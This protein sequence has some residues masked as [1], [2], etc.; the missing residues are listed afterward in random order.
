MAKYNVVERPSS[1][2]NDNQ[3]PF[4]ESLKSLTRLPVVAGVNIRNKEALPELDFI[5]PTGRTKEPYP[6]LSMSNI[7]AALPDEPETRAVCVLTSYKTWV[8]RSVTYVQATGFKPKQRKKG[9][10]DDNL[11]E[12]ED[13]TPEEVLRTSKSY[14]PG[15]FG[16]V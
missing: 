7:L 11:N 9:K 6:S 3:Y 10:E 1:L 4:S 12:E 2:K 13:D 5:L 15:C 14:R 16:A 8:T